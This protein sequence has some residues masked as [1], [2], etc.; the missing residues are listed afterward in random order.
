M[1]SENFRPDGTHRLGD[2]QT[3]RSETEIFTLLREAGLEILARRRLF[4]LMN[5]PQNSRSRCHRLWWA[6]LSRALARH[7]R[8][9]ALI[10]PILYPL[11]RRLVEL[12]APGSSSDLL[13][14]R[15]A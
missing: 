13:I 5:E 1:L 8:L 9:G 4:V 7:P 6:M 10:G 2:D 12:P 15:R 14:C 11:E 3:D